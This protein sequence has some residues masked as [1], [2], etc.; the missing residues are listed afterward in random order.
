MQIDDVAAAGPLVQSVDVLR[1]QHRRLPA[2]LQGSQREVSRVRPG[3]G[4][5]R[6]PSM[7]RAQ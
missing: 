6:Q 4:I 1:D 7:L 3:G 2:A 5:R